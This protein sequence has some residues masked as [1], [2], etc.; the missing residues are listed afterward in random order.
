MLACSALGLVVLIAGFSCSGGSDDPPPN[1][2]PDVIARINAHTD[3]ADLHGEFDVSMGW[4]DSWEPGDPRRDTALHYAE[5]A[6]A[7][8]EAIGCP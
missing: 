6:V 1:V 4:V 2:N 5:T 8:M 7:R 3:C